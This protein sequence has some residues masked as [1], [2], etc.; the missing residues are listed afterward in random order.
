V[1]LRSCK[2]HKNRRNRGQSLEKL[3]ALW[4]CAAGHKLPPPENRRRKAKLQESSLSA[5]DG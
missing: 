4:L 2:H 5:V 1:L 3:P